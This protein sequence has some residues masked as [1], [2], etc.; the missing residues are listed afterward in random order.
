MQNVAAGSGLQLHA[1]ISSGG[2]AQVSSRLGHWLVIVAVV[3]RGTKIWVVVA[4]G[5]SRIASAGWFPVEER[6]RV[7]SPAEY[8]VFDPPGR[9]LLTYSKIP[10][11][12]RVR[13]STD[14]SPYIRS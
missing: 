4:D 14:T 3:E 12:I 2:Q 6:S 11:R 1:S 13:I 9:V 8:R 5:S 10:I 7:A